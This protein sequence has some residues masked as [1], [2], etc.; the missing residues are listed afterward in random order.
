MKQRILATFLS[1]CMLVGLLPTTALATEPM[2]E[3]Q[4]PVAMNDTTEDTETGAEQSPLSGYCGGDT[5]AG[6][7]SYTYGADGTQYVYDNLTWELTENG[8]DT[9]AL[10]ITGNGVMADWV[11]VSGAIRTA[12]VSS[13]WSSYSKYITEVRLNGDIQ[14]GDRAFQGLSSL[15]A[16]DFP[17]GITNIPT[18]AFADC[19]RLENITIPDT[20]TEIGTAAFRACDAITSI[21]VPESVTT[22]GEYLFYS[23]QNLRDVQLP[24]NLTNLPGYMFK[25][26]AALEEISFPDGLTSIGIG[27]FEG[28]TS[29]R[30]LE[31]PSGL[32]SIESSAFKGCT[33]LADVDLSNT[34][35]VKIPENLFQGISRLTSVKLPDTVKKIENHAFAETGITQLMLPPYVDWIAGYSLDG[36]SHI[37]AVTMATEPFEEYEETESGASGDYWNRIGSQLFMDIADGS[38]VYL[39]GDKMPLA[40]TGSY[41]DNRIDETKTALALTNGGTFLMDTEFEA[42]TL[43]DPVKHANIF[44]SW[45]TSDDFQEGTEVTGSAVPNKTYYAKWTESTYSLSASSLEFDPISYGTASEAKAVSIQG[46]GSICSVLSSNPNVFTAEIVGDQVL[47][48]PADTLDAGTYRETIFITASDNATFFLPVSIT[49]SKASASIGISANPSAL[50]GGGTVTLTVNKSGLPQNAAVSVSGYSGILDTGNGTYTVTLP[51]AT[52]DYTF[53][54]QYQGDIN[55]LP[56]NAKCTVSVTQYTP[57]VMDNPPSSGSGYLVSLDGATDGGTVT[58]RPVR[59][60]QGELVTITVTPDPGYV[61]DSLTVQKANGTAVPL[62]KVSDSVYTFQMPD[63]RVTVSATFKAAPVHSFTDV[64]PADYYYDAV[65][66]AAANGVTNGITATTFGPN[67]AVS[68]AQMVTFL[69]RASGSPK[70]TGTNLFADVSTSDYYYDAVL[71]AVANGVTKG[72]SS[73]TFSPDAAVTRAQAVTFQWRAA[74]APAAAGSSFADVPA[75]AYFANAVAWAVANGI[76]NGTSSTTFSPDAVVTR[77]QAVAFLYRA[78]Q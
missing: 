60:D 58:V 53:T 68:R 43:A 25:E 45:Y 77:A 29:L 34:Q 4:P 36:C 35:L 39:V 27:A 52:A 63:S 41:Y 48:S 12:V 24:S 74:G 75:D 72:T 13:P 49:I 6:K 16:F 51:N 69:W 37:I 56:A 10:S 30:Y 14:F 19:V 47:V 59:A 50:S 8:S 3:Q 31:L 26:C 38:I 32:T 1:L 21:S 28:C 17:E 9:Y 5:A 70:A 67:M 64:K 55:H 22:Y 57:P 76:T 54:V 66:W 2:T 73:T 18:Y 78:A 11:Y 40:F 7:Y 33:G 71:W 65:L 62:T 42:N 44:S 61:L 20:V 23:C 15:T 46:G